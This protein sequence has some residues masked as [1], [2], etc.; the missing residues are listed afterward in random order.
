MIS[1]SPHHTV[2]NPNRCRGQLT[3]HTAVHDTDHSLLQQA[4]LKATFE[5]EKAEESE[6]MRNEAIA[7][8]QPTEVEDPEKIKNEKPPDGR[9]G[10]NRIWAVENLL[11]PDTR[12]GLRKMHMEKVGGLVLTMQKK[13]YR[14]DQINAVVKALYLTQTEADMKPAWMIFDVAGR[15]EV[16]LSDFHDNLKS[17]GEDI[18]GD[19]VGGIEIPPF[20]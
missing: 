7:R 3:R 4:E 5:K 13:M 1:L 2:S 18:P 20:V 17:I 19:K 9:D 10:G 15:G 12:A 14:A 6:R 16:V 11:Q 8:G